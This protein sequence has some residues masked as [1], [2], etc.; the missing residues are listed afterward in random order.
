MAGVGEKDGSLSL[1]RLINVI[2]NFI[3]RQWISKDYSVNPIMGF[4]SHKFSGCNATVVP[5][6]STVN[7]TTELLELPVSLSIVHCA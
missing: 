2:M 6:V 1:D 3:G 4:T 5:L 7:L